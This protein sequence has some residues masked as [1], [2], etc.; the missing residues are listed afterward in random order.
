MEK[1]IRARQWYG[2]LV[3]L[4]AVVTGLICVAGALSNAF[5]LSDPIASGGRLG[6]SL[7]SFEAYQ[8]TRG[9]APEDQRPSADT[10]S[11]ATLRLATRR[12]A[13]IESGSACSRPAKG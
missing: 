13:R 9:A 3:C 10:A 7:S 2:Y 6:E 12:C 5:D 11:V 1:P 4:V 8:A